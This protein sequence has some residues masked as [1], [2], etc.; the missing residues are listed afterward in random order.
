VVLSLVAVA[1]NTGIFATAFRF[2][3]NKGRSWREVF[4]GALVAA[5]AFE[6]LKLVGG[7]YLSA[8]SQGRSRTFGAF[9][10]AA[11]LLVASYLLAQVTLLAAEL[12][13]V[14][15]E[16]SERRTSKADGSEEKA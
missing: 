11:G 8:G 5:I 7:V 15:A 13:A 12:N 16:R 9:S 4:P 10:A 2:L 1:V 14:L 6:V 3:S